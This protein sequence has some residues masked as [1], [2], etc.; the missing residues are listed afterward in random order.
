[1]SVGI[2]TNIKQAGTNITSVR[3][4]QFKI[5][6]DK[7]MDFTKKTIA[8]LV[9]IIL[10]VI[11]INVEYLSA[12]STEAVK[13]NT[14]Y[15]TYGSVIFSSQLSISYERLIYK[16]NKLQ[17]RGKLNFG[18]Y[19][20]HHL[21][22]DEDAKLCERFLSLSVVELIGLFEVGAGI[23]YT[24]HKL[25]GGFEA[26]PD[27]DYSKLYHGIGFYGNI[28]IRYSKNRFVIRTG[29]SIPELLYLSIGVNF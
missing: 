5:Q 7:N 25:A 18:D 4:E 21:D 15:A 2:Q 24:Q 9:G 11:L 6:N 14:I 29:M 16:K 10:M 23:S 26:K 3:R 20:G 17:T 28:G 1:M 8:K 12:Q 13:K 22:Y 19:L 27:V